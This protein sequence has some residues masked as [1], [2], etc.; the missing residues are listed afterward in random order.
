MG[1]GEKRARV[2][3]L[4]RQDQKHCLTPVDGLETLAG[5]TREKYCY[6]EIFAKRDC[7]RPGLI[8]KNQLHEPPGASVSQGL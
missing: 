6:T 1:I 7:L 2:I 4:S 5:A 3:G 8:Y